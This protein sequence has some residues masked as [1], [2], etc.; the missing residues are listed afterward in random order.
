MVVR[1]WEV[2]RGDVCRTSE[3]GGIGK[4][5]DPDLATVLERRDHVCPRGEEGKVPNAV[6]SLVLLNEL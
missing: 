3:R 5:V 4:A 6:G 1:W 2:Q